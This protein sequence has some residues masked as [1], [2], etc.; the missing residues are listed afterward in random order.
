MVTTAFP[1]DHGPISERTLLV[2]GVETPFFD[3]IFW[4]GLATLGFLPSTVFPVGLSEDG[5]PIGIQAIGAEFDERT[6]IE[7]AR[8][9][10]QEIGGFMPP[11]G[12]E[13]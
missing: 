8:L 9:M 13:D 4:A 3:Q 1:H 11:T 6:T 10:A 5:L 2:N 7:F 12:F